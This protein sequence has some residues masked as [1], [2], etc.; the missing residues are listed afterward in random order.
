M[1]L[2]GGGTTKVGDPTG[3]DEQPP[4]AWTDDAI[5]TQHGRHQTASSPSTSTFGDGPTDAVMVN[6]AD[7]LDDLAIHSSSCATTDGI[8]RSTGCSVLRLG[9]D[10]GLSA[11]SHLTFLEF[12]YMILQAYDFLELARRMA[13]NA[14]LQMGGSDQWGNIVNG[15]ELGR[16]IGTGSSCSA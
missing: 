13:T 8:S 10:S 3:K 16:R 2:M 15:V 12:N 1:V 4:A 14:A 9:Q 11:S 6:N 7:W 5:A